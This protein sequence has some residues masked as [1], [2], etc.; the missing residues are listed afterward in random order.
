LFSV[1]FVLLAGAVFQVSLVKA[2][3]CLAG[4]ARAFKSY[5]LKLLAFS[6]ALVVVPVLLVTAQAVP[7]MTS[8]YGPQWQ[9]SGQALAVLAPSIGLAFIGSSC[10][11]ILMARGHLRLLATWKLFSLAALGSWLWVTFSMRPMFLAAV[12]QIAAVNSVLYILL[13]VAIVYASISPFG[14]DS[15]ERFVQ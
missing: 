9:L 15:S 10:S 5:A 14:V 8:L 13:I 6:T 11:S 7:L 4:S 12:A 2:S 3:Q 1:P